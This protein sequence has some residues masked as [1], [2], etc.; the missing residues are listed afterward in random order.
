M[1]DGE[2][3]SNQGGRREGAGRKKGTGRAGVRNHT[4]ALTDAAWE[5][6]SDFSKRQGF[7]SVCAWAESLALEN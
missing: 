1:S 6:L 2:T 5:A 4:L 7:K 3:K